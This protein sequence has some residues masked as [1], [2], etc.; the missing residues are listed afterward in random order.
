M[1]K[2]ISLILQYLVYELL[3][4]T[5][6]TL[7]L[8]NSNLIK[9]KFRKL[10][11]GIYIYIYR[12]TK[13]K[14][15]PAKTVYMYLYDKDLF[16]LE[17]FKKSTILFNSRIWKHFSK[18]NNHY[19]N[20]SALYQKEYSY[21]SY[22]KSLDTCSVLDITDFCADGDIQYLKKGAEITL[23]SPNVL[24]KGL[25][26][27]TYS[28]K[29]PD[30]YIACLQDVIVHKNASILQKTN[31]Q[32]NWISYEPQAHPKVKFVANYWKQFIYYD[33]DKKQVLIPKINRPSRTVKEA[34]LLNGRCSENYF[35]WILESLSRVYIL[36]K[37]SFFN[38]ENTPL[39]ILDSMPIT[40]YDTLKILAP[41]RPVI[42]YSEAENIAVEKLY[43]LSVPTLHYDDIDIPFLKGASVDFDYFRFVR[44]RV[45]NSKEYNIISEL[46]Y[47]KKIFVTRPKGAARSIK[48]QKAIEK[49]LVSKGFK[50][51]YPENMSFIEQAQCFEN[52][53]VIV[54]VN[55]AALTNLIFA[56]QKAKVFILINEYNEDF[57]W[58]YNL[59]KHVAGCDVFHI[60]GK[61][62]GSIRF[63]YPY[64]ERMEKV[65]Q[66]YKIDMHDLKRFI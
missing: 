22:Y 21:I 55:G 9:K 1:K 45:L 47:P 31:D 63:K 40:H 14:R 15:L 39:L 20:K 12:H 13:A 30:S 23:S 51:V 24:N 32:W 19:L 53:D 4:I 59:A 7:N 36:E 2:I 8:I 26:E 11:A 43:V 28:I 6:R 66:G 48:N 57:T 52:A 35:H 27:K 64:E 25:C 44:N 61:P 18:H 37:Q 33:N 29:E 38:L 50:I 16:E 17:Q 60:T 56:N 62:V 10:L 54:G 5:L 46:S 34:I 49:Y 41:D 58:H 65:K 3:L 42:Y